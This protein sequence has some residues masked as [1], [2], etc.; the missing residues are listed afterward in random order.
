MI[1]GTGDGFTLL[2]LLIVIAIV[3][4]LACAWPLTTRLFPTQRLRN[5]TQRLT[6]SLREVRAAALAGGAAHSLEIPESEGVYRAESQTY[7]LPAGLTLHFHETNSISPA[8]R[9][10]FYPDGSATG[11]VLG[12]EFGGHAEQIAIG[13]VSGRIEIIE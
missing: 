13:T 7:Y 2:E 5:E 1:S 4:L 9:V 11:G 10:T 8:P 6:H 12:L 3:A